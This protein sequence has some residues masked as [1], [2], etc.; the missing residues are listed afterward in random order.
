MNKWSFWRRDWFVGLLVALAFMLAANS[1][2]M[3]SL[4]RKAYDLG[5]L[6][7]SRTPSDKIAVIAIDEQS[8]AN[9]GRWPWPRAIHAKMLDV[10]AAGHPKVIGYTAFFFEP[11]VDAGLQYIQSIAGLLDNSTLKDTADPANQADLAKLGALLQEAEQNLD[12][13]QK[14]SASMANANDVLLPMFFE[15]GEPQGKP[16]NQLPDY[17]LR[18]NL[19]NV[20]DSGGLGEFPLPAMGVLAPIPVSGQQGAGHRASEQLSGCGRRDTHRTAGESTITTSIT[21]L[22]R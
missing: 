6:A 17:V 20:K 3:Q 12:N 10:L 8:I 1:E 9:L 22:C 21:R 5:V 13:D 19:T 11:Q 2:F 16:D 7:S 4:E 18:N 15:L 14:L